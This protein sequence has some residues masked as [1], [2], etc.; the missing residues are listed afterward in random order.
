MLSFKRFAF[1]EIAFVG[2]DFRDQG[3]LE[4][5]CTRCRSCRVPFKKLGEFL[6]KIP[7]QG[8]SWA[9]YVERYHRRTVT[10]FYSYY[11]VKVALQR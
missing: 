3:F 5:V 1:N 8:H 7:L 10:S 9:E 4:V 6:P 2:C 11:S